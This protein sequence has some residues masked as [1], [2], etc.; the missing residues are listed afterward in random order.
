MDE[1]VNHSDWDMY[2]SLILKASDEIREKIKVD[3][4]SFL[5]VHGQLWADTRSYV[6]YTALDELQKICFYLIRMQETLEEGK[7]DPRT[8]RLQR[9]LYEELVEDQYSKI[10]RLLE[11][12]ITLILFK[13]TNN[14]DYFRHFI[15]L[16][17]LDNL[18]F[19]NLDLEEFYSAKSAN[20]DDSI[21]HQIEMIER[22]ESKIDLETC[23][24]LKEKKGI[25]NINLR[26]SLLNSMRQRIKAGIPFMYSLE[27]LLFGFS[28]KGSYSYAS[29][30]IH[31]S[32]LK[33][34][35]PQGEMNLSLHK[36]LGLLGFSIIKRITDLIEEFNAPHILKI[37]DGLD[38]TSPEDLVFSQTIR[39]IK[40]GDFVLAYGD[41][42]EVLEIKE[43]SYG[44]RSYRILY[45][46][47]KPKPNIKEDW[48]PA[49]YI[50]RIFDSDEIKN[51]V[52]QNIKETLKDNFHQIDNNELQEILR[53]GVLEIWNIGLRNHLKKRGKIK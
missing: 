22:I 16:E 39:N 52:I 2:I 24:Y 45:L 41:L 8:E 47:E 27:K 14:I 46:A 1:K 43:S 6:V 49:K 3:E 15:L 12:L 5:F 40:V 51:R 34:I 13:T 50:Q 7:V 18:L 48:F 29:E 28:Y 53:K 33:N 9:L 42:A 31:Y 20:I 10:R 11:I 17:E 23:W 26:S 32:P 37:I 36:Y 19:S 35:L 21:S 38:N 4:N 44:Y 30:S 25:R